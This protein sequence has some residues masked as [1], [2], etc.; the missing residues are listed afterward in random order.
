MWGRYMK[1]DFPVADP[2]KNEA[3]V[4]EAAGLCPQQAITID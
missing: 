2:Q 3:A 1:A 4:R